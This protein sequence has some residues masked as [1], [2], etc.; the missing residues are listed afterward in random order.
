MKAKL[1]EV[2]LF[3][4]TRGRLHDNL[5]E[6]TVEIH[7]TV[8][9][10]WEPLYEQF[11]FNFAQRGEL[12]ASVCVTHE[13]ATVVD[14]WAGDRDTEGNPWLAD[15][16]A[17]INSCTK[18][19]VALAC[20]LL[21][22][23]GLL[24]FDAPVSEIWPE[25]AHG[26]KA[27]VTTR[28]M[29]NHTTGVAAFRDDLP[30]GAAFDWD[31]MCDRVAAEEPWWE[32]GTRNGYHLMSFGWVAGEL[33]RR[34]SGRSLGAFFREDVAEPAAADFWIGLP[35]EEHHRVSPLKQFRPGKN[36]KFAAFTNAFL[37]DPS[38]LQGRAWRNRGGAKGDSPAVWSAELG[39]GGGI[40]NARGLARIYKT[41]ATGEFV[42]RSQLRRMSSVSVGTECD[43]MLLLPT[44]FSE[45]F[46]LRMD[47]R[48]A[49]RGD[50]DSVNVREGA[51]GHVG[52]GGSIGFADPQI[53][54]S[55]GY[56]MNQMGKS[57]LLDARGE[58]LVDVAYECAT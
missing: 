39:G 42:G 36:E 47:N 35:P 48:N 54:L 13:D 7:G 55:M 44:R 24:D 50:R 18:G 37:A 26:A 30:E 46:M 20:H 28:M 5:A 15:T 25:F 14:L 27:D 16:V 40:A 22:D 49:R 9:S 1:P 38:G 17:V 4:E 2:A 8:A 31:Y 12:G 57:V 6:M 3:E 34:A 23:R 19:G 32:P 41:C 29:L 53:G 21:A 33:V 51:F 10:G 45:G 58:T 56:V 52:A 43:A 11:A